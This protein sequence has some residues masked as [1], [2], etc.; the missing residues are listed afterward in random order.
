ME[1]RHD[2][3]PEAN[4]LAAQDSQPSERTVCEQ[5]YPDLARELRDL[6]CAGA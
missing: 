6:I 5:M 4:A 1:N 2:E 3:P